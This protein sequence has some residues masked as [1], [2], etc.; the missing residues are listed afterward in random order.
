MSMSRSA[1]SRSACRIPHNVAAM[2][3]PRPKHRCIFCAIMRIGKGAIMTSHGKFAE[4]AALAGDP[5]R[6]GMLHALLGGRALTASE[7][8]SIAGVTAQTASGHLARLNAVDLVSV[9]KQ[10]RH[11]YYR[12]ASPA[13]ARMM[14][15]IMEVASGQQ[16]SRKRLVVGPRDE[17]LRAARICYDHLAGQLGVALADALVAAGHAE[18][19][20]EGGMVTDGGVRF[21]NRI[22][23]TAE[24]LRTTN[25]RPTRRRLCRPCLDWSER[26]IHLGG[27]LGAA[28]CRLSFDAGWIRRVEGSRAVTITPS[29]HQAYREHF[30][31]SL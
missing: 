6:A 13:V 27:A 29:G 2:L 15:A 17:A 23:V 21:L 19:S 9:I 31:L 28:L 26:R 18:F 30:G 10:G 1:G 4:V 25:G 8:A 5:A 20:D 22:G 3:R 12:L 14:E 11:R 16:P 24:A 7:L